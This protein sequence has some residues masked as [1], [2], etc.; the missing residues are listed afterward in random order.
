ML[1]TIRIKVDTELGYMIINSVDYDSKVHI[2]YDAELVDDVEL[3]EIATSKKTRVR[4]LSID[5]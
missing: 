5:A 1:E 4:K 2:K 3:I